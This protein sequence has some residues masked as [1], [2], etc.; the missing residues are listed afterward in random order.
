MLQWFTGSALSVL[1]THARK[2]PGWLSTLVA[3]N[4]GI[5]A[6]SIGEP[7]SLDL[8]MERRATK[9]EESQIGLPRV[10]CER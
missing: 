10:P 8:T 7:N 1:R 9:S 6:G 4:K 2:K 3:G 5:P